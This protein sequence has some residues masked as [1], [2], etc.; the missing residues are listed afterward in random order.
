[1]SSPT[2]KPL[3]V[4]S[5]RGLVRINASCSP[6]L[7]A[8]DEVFELYSELSLRGSAVGA[9]TVDA[10][11]SGLGFLDGTKDVLEL[12][13]EIVDPRSDP[14]RAAAPTST[15]VRVRSPELVPSLSLSPQHRAPRLKR[16]A[17]HQKEGKGTDSAAI[18]SASIAQDLGALRNRKGDTGGLGVGSYLR[19]GEGANGGLMFWDRERDLAIEV[20]EIRS[21]SAR[22]TSTD[23]PFVL[24]ACSSPGASSHNT[25]SRL[26]WA[27]RTA[28]ASLTAPPP[29]GHTSSS[30]AA[31]QASCPSSCS[32][33]NAQHHPPRRAG[34]P[35]LP[36]REWA[37][38]SARGRLRT[39]W[40]I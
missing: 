14:P 19:Q 11:G 17:S 4:S 32:G 6:V 12:E 37:A 10:T 40:T 26:L 7:D 15:D 31:G 33:P 2:S 39:G 34:R 24:V 21:C 23:A 20:R 5:P 29:R 27:T 38:S 8:D 35:R 30:S 13:L 9:G 1:M 16:T 22:G 18:V 36:R 25:S 28:R 3:P